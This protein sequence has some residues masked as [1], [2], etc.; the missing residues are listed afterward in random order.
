MNTTTRPR[1]E[2]EQ[3]R[4]A[5]QGQQPK[6]STRLTPLKIYL[7]G[8]NIISALLWANL[9]YITVSFILT[10]RPG[11]PTPF[12]NRILAS[13]PV[14][15]RWLGILPS[16]FSRLAGSYGYKN[17]GK[18]TRYTQSL[19]ALEVVHAALGWVRS[20]VF[21]TA[22]QVFSRVYTVWGVVEAV[23][24]VCSS[25]VALIRPIPIRCL[26]LCSSLGLSLRLS[27]T[28][29]TPLLFSVSRPKH[30]TG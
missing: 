26:R 5:R 14:A 19:A 20:P 21:T 24:K 11:Q 16:P 28:L 12:W 23:P 4:L 10:S 29:T 25:L 27:G 13:S 2:L 3:Q 9:L 8:Y 18:L 17:L 15:R 30:S 6:T 1:A 7:L 22:S